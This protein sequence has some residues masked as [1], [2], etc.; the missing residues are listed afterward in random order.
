M[1]DYVLFLS[2]FPLSNVLQLIQP[3]LEKSEAS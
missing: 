2:I 1:C 3:F